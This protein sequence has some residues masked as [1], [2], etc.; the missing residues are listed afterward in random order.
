MQ[1]HVQALPQTAQQQPAGPGGG[2]ALCH[3]TAPSS[4]K[5][6]FTYVTSNIF[7][8]DARAGK[9]VMQVPY[10]TLTLSLIYF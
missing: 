3:P 10:S 1:V 6:T 9:P 8:E 7:S 2:A 5:I 4:V